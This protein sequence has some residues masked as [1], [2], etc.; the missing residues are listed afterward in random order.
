MTKTL[1]SNNNILCKKKSVS[2]KNKL[3]KTSKPNISAKK[4]TNYIEFPEYC[5]MLTM[6]MRPVSDAFIEKLA[7]DMLNWVKTTKKKTFPSF[8]E[9]RGICYSTFRNWKERVPKLARAHEHVLE[10]LGARR[11]EGGLERK[12]DPNMVIKSMPI[13]SH[14]WRK[15]EEDR[16]ARRKVDT[17][18]ANGPIT[19]VMKEFGSGMNPKDT[20]VKEKG[21]TS[22]E[23][24]S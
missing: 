2:Q 19:I 5:D 4:P 1:V 6:R 3:C 20:S 16:D 24:K 22:L 8:L 17:S 23:E 11:E 15:L 7:I 18:K 14:D 13:Y 12:Y 21:E 10:I 9:E